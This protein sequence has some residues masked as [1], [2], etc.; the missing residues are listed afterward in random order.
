M[1]PG[2]IRMQNWSPIF[3][4]FGP[5]LQFPVLSMLGAMS[6]LLMLVGGAPLRRIKRWVNDRKGREPAR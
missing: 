3:A 4:Y 2:E 1:V 6:G 5:E